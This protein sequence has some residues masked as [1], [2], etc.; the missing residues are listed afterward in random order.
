MAKPVAGS[1]GMRVG[2]AAWILVALLAV[3]M[4]EYSFI[5]YC[6]IFFCY[7]IIL[8]YIVGLEGVSMREKCVCG[9]VVWMDNE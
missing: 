4:R 9:S 1:C 8:Y 5:V 2:L 7:F 6:Y 3:F